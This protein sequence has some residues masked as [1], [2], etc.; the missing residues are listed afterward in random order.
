MLV[1][2]DVVVLCVVD[3]LVQRCHIANEESTIWLQ[4]VSQDLGRSSEIL[5]MVECGDAL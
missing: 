2:D 5:D 4:E 3:W 1:R